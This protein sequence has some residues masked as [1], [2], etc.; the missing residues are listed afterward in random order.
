M[1]FGR[2]QRKTEEQDEVPEYWITYS[3]LMVSLLMTFALL[4]FLAMA[5]V[6]AEVKNAE[7]IIRA[8]RDAITVAGGDLASKGTGV[9]LDSAT[10]TLIMNSELL[11][12][13]GSAQLKPQAMGQIRDIA[14][15]FLPRLIKQP[16]VDSLLQEI[17]VEGHTDTV[18]TYLS[19]L[20]LSQQRA[21]SVMHALVESTY[22]MS[23][24]PRLR[25]L[26]VA[27]G[28]SEV[29]PVVVN[30]Q[31]DAAKSRRIEIHLRFRDDAILKKI[32]E[33]AKTESDGQ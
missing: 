2:R 3:D 16:S 24:A 13:Y 10:G 7:R 14:T 9:V 31:I 29:R 1:I 26:I 8:N 22:G 15:D 28:K 12:G 30:G 5:K 4:L 17:V 21:Y 25:D 23:Y 33:S 32:F 27:S 19:N 11:F 20:Q 6:Q 18:G